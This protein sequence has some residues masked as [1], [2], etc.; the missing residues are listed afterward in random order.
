MLNAYLKRPKYD[1]LD[2][3]QVITDSRLSSQYFGGCRG[4]GDGLAQAWK[5]APTASNFSINTLLE[6]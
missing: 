1:F 5:G 2:Q 3:M 4:A 6:A